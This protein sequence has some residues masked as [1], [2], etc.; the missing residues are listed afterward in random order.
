M[1]L[2]VSPTKLC[3]VS[4]GLQNAVEDFYNPGLSFYYYEDFHPRLLSTL[5]YGS[6]GLVE[7]FYICVVEKFCMCLRIVLYMSW[8]GFIGVVGFFN[9]VIPLLSYLKLVKIFSKVA[10]CIRKVSP[11]SS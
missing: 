5:S 6:A 2:E 3:T 11:S 4:V 7:W 1:T 9:F 8:N 10:Q